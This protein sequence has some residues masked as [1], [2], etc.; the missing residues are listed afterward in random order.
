MEY[1]LKFDKDSRTYLEDKEA[2]LVLQSTISYGDIE[3]YFTFTINFESTYYSGI[4]GKLRIK[5]D[6]M[7]I[8]IFDENPFVYQSQYL[9]N[10]SGYLSYQM[11]DFT[12]EELSSISKTKTLRIQYDSAPIT[13]N[14]NDLRS[15]RN[16]INTLSFKTY[17]DIKKIEKYYR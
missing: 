8:Q 7:L 15:I 2:F 1:Q 17:D 11:T 5:T 12:E 9:H 6:D 14:D 13:I 10:D 16:F 4:N 3:P